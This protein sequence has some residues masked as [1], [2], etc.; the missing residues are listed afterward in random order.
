MCSGG[1]SRDQ[2]SLRTNLKR[3]RKCVCREIRKSVTEKQNDI[4]QDDKTSQTKKNYLWAIKTC[5]IHLCLAIVP[6]KMIRTP[7]DMTWKIKEVECIQLVYLKAKNALRSWEVIQL[8]E[9][10][11][12]LVVV[13]THTFVHTCT[14]TLPNLKC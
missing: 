1:G 12:I 6:L 11:R 8:V 10:S 14:Y 13:S 9:H 3:V 2:V 5:L 4:N 7:L